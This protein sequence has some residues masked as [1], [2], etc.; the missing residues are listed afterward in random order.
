MQKSKLAFVDETK[1]RRT[2]GTHD[3]LVQIYGHQ[4]IFQSKWKYGE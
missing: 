4:R 1:E 2:V 3:F